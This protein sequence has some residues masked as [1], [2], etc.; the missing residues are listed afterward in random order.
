MF[1]K[2]LS[3]LVIIAALALLAFQLLSSDYPEIDDNLLFQRIDGSKQTF[4]ELKGQPLAVTF[5]SPTCTIC[6]HEVKDWNTLYQQNGKDYQFE[7]LA[8]SMY[9]DRPDMV[10][11]ASQKKGMTY[12][13]YLDLQNQLAQAFGNIV[14]T[15]TTFLLD[16]SGVIIYRHTGKLDFQL[17]AEKLS[18]LTG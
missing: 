17:L 16:A 8:L 2:F 4:K 10:I 7:L 14:A 9:Y 13:V 1:A 6:M 15:P 5:W 12:P 3:F 11:Q 18:Q